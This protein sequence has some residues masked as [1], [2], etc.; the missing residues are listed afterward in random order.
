VPSPLLYDG[1]LD[2]LKGNTGVLSA[3]DARTG[4]PDY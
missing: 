4:K 3:F 2:V 1:T